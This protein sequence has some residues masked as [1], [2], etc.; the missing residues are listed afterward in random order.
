VVADDTQ[1]R[2]SVARELCPRF[3][4]L[5]AVSFTSAARKLEAG[6]RFSALIIDLGLSDPRGASWFLARL[7]DHAFEGPRILLS[8]AIRPEHASSLSQSCVSHFALALPWAPG[9][10]RGRIERA[11]GVREVRASARDV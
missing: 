2:I 3:D 7:V 1:V 4:L 8:R 6:E 9:A 5:H 11:L 10:L